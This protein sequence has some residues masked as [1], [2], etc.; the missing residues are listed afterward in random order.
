V[1][2]VYTKGLYDAYYYRAKCQICGEERIGENTRK[3]AKDFAL[4]AGWS[5]QHFDNGDVTICPECSSKGS[6]GRTY[7]E[8]RG[9]VRERAGFSPPKD[10]V[11]VFADEV[12][13]R[14]K[15]GKVLGEPVN[16]ESQDH[17]IVAA[18]FLGSGDLSG[19]SRKKSQKESLVEAVENFLG[20]LRL[21]P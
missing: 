9:W 21:M 14:V 19:Y 16:M 12:R 6:A 7:E 20:Y 13:D 18:Y 10:L 4:S 8:Y 5:V 2:I 11:S 1:N 15:G 17:L 3:G